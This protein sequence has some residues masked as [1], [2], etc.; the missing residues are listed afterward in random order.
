MALALPALASTATQTT[1]AVVTH[2][3]D[4]RTQANATVTVTGSDGTP[5]SG[6]VIFK[7]GSR[8]LGGAALDANGQA[9]AAIT[10]PGGEH[11]LRAVYVGS[12]SYQASASSASSVLATTSGSVNFAIT[13]SPASAS[14]TAGNAATTTVSVTPE[15]NSS[16][17]SPLFV[18]LSCSALPSQS[19]CGFTPT[20]VEILSNSTSA[21][22]STMVISTEAEGT[23]KLTAP[24]GSGRAASP[25]ALALLLPGIFGLGGLA[26]GARKRPW[27]QRL[28]LL[29]LIGLVTVVGTTGCSPLYDYY[30]HGPT[31]TPST[32]A[33]SYTITVTGQS[34]NGVTATTNSTTFAL[35]VN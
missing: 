21:L 25:M 20:E 4:G 11:A 14:V 15:N 28:V 5:A 33:G 9:T 34:S 23:T 7:D 16:L 10:L 26:W 19:S 32:P 8:Q 31:T 6:A 3:Q 24:A 18:T 12:S 27:M 13:V 1:L 29:A 22:T 2:D 35:T 30:H 17:T